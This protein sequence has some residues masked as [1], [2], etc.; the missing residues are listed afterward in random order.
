MRVRSRQLHEQLLEHT[1]VPALLGLVSRR[2]LVPH[3]RSF[4]GV[5]LGGLCESAA[6]V[7][8]MQAIVAAVPYFFQICVGHACFRSV[9]V[10]ALG[11]MTADAGNKKSGR[12]RSI[13]TQHP[14]PRTTIGL[15]GRL[16]DAG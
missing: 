11:R 16:L 6:W 1:S 9:S 2:C 7:S 13:E 10:R 5:V 8:R 4:V 15:T 12:F 3:L 14:D